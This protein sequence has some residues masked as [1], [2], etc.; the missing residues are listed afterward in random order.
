[1]ANDSMDFLKG[2]FIGGIAGALASLLYAPKSGDELR[3][4]IRK[5]ATE[6]QDDA[7]T[8]FKHFQKNTEKLLDDTEKKITRIRK[9][10]EDWIEDIQ[11]RT[12]ETFEEGREAVEKQR[13][14]IKS[15]VDAG[16]KAYKKATK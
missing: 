11:K 7:E 1:M 14:G 3:G 4:D 15:G 13:S 10:T 2:L 16:V 6:L 12:L 8:K 5:K 9:D